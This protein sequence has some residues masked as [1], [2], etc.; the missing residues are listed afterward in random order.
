MSE[1]TVTVRGYG[2]ATVQPDGVRL[3]LTVRRVAQTPDAALEEAT[4]GSHM[5]EALLEELG[6]DPSAW[7]TA[8]V[9]V[10]E[11]RRW[12][13]RQGQ[14][15]KTGYSAIA[16][17]DVLLEDISQAGALM[18]EAV[19]RAEAQITGPWW[20]VAPAN[21][22][23][24]EACRRAVDDATRKA[25]AIASAVEGTL[26]AVRSVTEPAT[27][28]HTF[29]PAAGFARLSGHEEPEEMMLQPGGLEIGASVEV[30]FD[31]SGGR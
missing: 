21:Q 13:E 8:M 28:P 25:R 1:P 15:M 3:R 6:I 31:L 26:G 5:L 17:L 23:V 27:Y 10:Q 12:D 30:C 9:A 11:E 7:T 14:E 24:E 29:Q 18:R 20:H 4:H 2:I 19:V 22:A 16:G